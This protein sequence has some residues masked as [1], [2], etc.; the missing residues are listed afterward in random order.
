MISTSFKSP[1][2][3]LSLR[4]EKIANERTVFKV[5]YLMDEVSPL[6]TLTHNGEKIVPVNLGRSKDY[7]DFFSQKPEVDWITSAVVMDKGYRP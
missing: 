4:S 6:G 2:S 7:L 1:D 5:C 3:I